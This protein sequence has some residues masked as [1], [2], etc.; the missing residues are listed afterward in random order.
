[1]PKTNP[2]KLITVF[3]SKPMVEIQKGRSKQNM[4]KRKKMDYQSHEGRL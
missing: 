1:M 3:K 4:C 2:L